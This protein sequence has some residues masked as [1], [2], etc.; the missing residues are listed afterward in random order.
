MTPRRLHLLY[1]VG[2]FPQLSETFVANEV[3]G[4]ADRG[5]RVT[6]AFLR[7]GDGPP[8]RHPGVRVPL[9]RLPL[10][11]PF[12]RGLRCREPG[13]TLRRRLYAAAAARWV[14]GRVGGDPPDLVHAHFVNRPALVAREFAARLGVPFT[15]L[16]HAGDRLGTTAACVRER[17]RSV[18][19]AH[20]R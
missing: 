11:L 6:L 18:T 4:L 3:L 16:T 17:L 12:A 14:A 1:V 5:H 19:S 13:E 7:R 15:F 10:Q 9:R 2:T 8:V 20:P